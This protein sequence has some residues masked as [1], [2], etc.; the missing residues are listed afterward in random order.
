[1]APA[2]DEAATTRP[3][4]SPQ[5]ARTPAGCA[6]AA[7]SPL[8]QAKPTGDSPFQSEN[9]TGSRIGSLCDHLPPYVFKPPIEAVV[10]AWGASE[11]YQLGLNTENDVHVPTVSDAAQAYSSGGSDG[12]GDW[13][14]PVP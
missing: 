10:F 2:R 13:H 9:S 8:R 5:R 4:G 14:H 6:A 7:G 12:T 3:G 1:M 11:D